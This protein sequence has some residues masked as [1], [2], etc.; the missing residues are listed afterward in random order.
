[1]SSQSQS[2]DVKE[3]KP[4]LTSKCV[5]STPNF[6]KS[7]FKKIP[8]ESSDKTPIKAEFT[9]SFFAATNP[10]ATGPPP[11]IFEVIALIFVSSFGNEG[12]R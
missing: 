6:S 9:P 2:D 5:V 3:R 10:V 8:F 7:F 4:L 12:I 1:M 11:E